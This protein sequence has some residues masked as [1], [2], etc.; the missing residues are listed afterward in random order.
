MRCPHCQHQNHEGARFCAA[1]GSSLASSY[2]ARGSHLPPGAAFC[3]YSGTPL[4][5]TTTT[6]GPSLLGARPQTPQVYTPPYLAAKILTSCSAL[7]GERKRVTAPF[8]D[9]KGSLEW[10]AN[11]DLEEART[12]LDPVLE[13]MMAAVHRYEG[14]VNQV[15][16]DGV[17]G[18]LAPPS[19]TKITHC[20]RAMRPWRRWNDLSSR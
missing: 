7:D 14:T 16:G 13:R 8:A 9:L 4:T 18:S 6:A 15:I 11:H 10:L 17:V 12:L 20:A 2:A 5:G 19:R 3:D 1:G